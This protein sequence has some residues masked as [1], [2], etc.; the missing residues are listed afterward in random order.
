MSLTQKIKYCLQLDSCLKVV[1][2]AKKFNTITEDDYNRLKGFMLNRLRNE[3]IGFH[4]VLA[5][6]GDRYNS[7]KKIED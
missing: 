7:I 5:Y 1:R 2:K 3:N 6:G 4:K